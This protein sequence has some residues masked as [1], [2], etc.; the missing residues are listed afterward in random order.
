M[1]ADPIAIAPDP[2][3]AELIDDFLAS[4]LSPRTRESY[5]GDLVIFL[6]WVAE[7]GKHPREV[8]RPDVVPSGRRAG[9]SPAG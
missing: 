7:R 1:A 8:S 6:R 5:A 3:L 9:R 4:Q 2:E